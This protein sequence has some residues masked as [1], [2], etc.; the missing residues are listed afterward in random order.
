MLKP[1]TNPPLSPIF[2]REDEKEKDYDDEPPSS[3]T[4]RKTQA[5]TRAHKYPAQTP[6]R[7]TFH[8]EKRFAEVDM[9]W[10]SMILP[11]VHLRKPCYDFSF[12]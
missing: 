6:A 7:G 3:L 4:C 5:L 11:Q 8:Q 10:V 12:L 1:I 2:S 9:D